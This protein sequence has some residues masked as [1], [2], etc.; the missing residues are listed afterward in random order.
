MNFERQVKNGNLK[1]PIILASAKG[2][3]FI[4]FKSFKPV[5]GDLGY[6]GYTHLCITFYYYNKYVGFIYNSIEKY[7]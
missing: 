3:C 5:V 6:Y 1:Y 4:P 2:E 7:V